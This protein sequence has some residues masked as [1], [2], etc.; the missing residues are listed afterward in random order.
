MFR[1]VLIGIGVIFACSNS[2]DVDGISFLK[3][4]IKTD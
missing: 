2:C 4:T 3:N 1:K